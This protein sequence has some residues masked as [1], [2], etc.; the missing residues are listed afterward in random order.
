MLNLYGSDY[1]VH[2]HIAES[3]L[4]AY[5][6][7]ES[8]DIPLAFCYLS[9]FGIPRDVEKAQKILNKTEYSSDDVLIML[10]DLNRRQTELPSVLA[11]VTDDSGHADL[12]R[13]PDIYVEQGRLENAL[14]VLERE[15]KDLKEFSGPDNIPA[16]DIQ[17]RRQLVD[18]YDAQGQYVELQNLLLASLD[19]HSSSRK[20]ETDDTNVQV[21]EVMSL[22]AADYRFLKRWEDAKEVETYL[23]NQAMPSETSQT[24]THDKEEGITTPK[25]CPAT[26]HPV[27][28]FSQLALGALQPGQDRSVP[29]ISTIPDDEPL[30]WLFER[31]A[32]YIRHRK[33]RN[34]NRVLT[35]TRRVCKSLI[36]EHLVVL[37]TMNQLTKVNMT[38]GRYQVAEPWAKDAI[39]MGRQWGENHPSVLV[40]KGNLAMISLIMDK[41]DRAESLAKELI[42]IAQAKW[43]EDHDLTQYGWRILGSTYGQ[44]GKMDE[45]EEVAKK[46]VAQNKKLY[47]DENMSTLDAV[48]NLAVIYHQQGDL[49]AAEEL[50]EEALRTCVKMLGNRHARSLKRMDHLSM[51]LFEQGETTAA[52]ILGESCLQKRRDVLGSQHPDTASSMEAMAKIRSVQE[53]Q[54]EAMLLLEECLLARKSV[55]GEGH[56]H[57]LKVLCEMAKVRVRQCRFD[58]AIS[59]LETCTDSQRRFLGLHHPDLMSSLSLLATIYQREGRHQSAIA[60]TAE[61]IRISQQN[62]GA[63]HPDT[64]RAIEYQKR[65]ERQGQ[66]RIN[67]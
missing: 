8:C 11:R 19:K 65:L 36:S 44:Q 38:L 67:P 45:A 51:I 54:E 56:P 13:V 1:R 46:L 42:H 66:P 21:H 30:L 28:A 6:W 64:R 58:D 37:D 29:G 60:S 41:L 62:Y 35:D 25:T 7:D 16:A 26:G 12:G 9:G 3:L 52:A 40:G 32:S 59:L 4:E 31:C 5:G 34:I 18:I 49:D 47:G 33:W 2:K 24:H 14:K 20:L 50:A 15:L 43:G 63:N 23:K 10:H 55:Y 39:Q 22:L 53:R 27:E 61:V 17:L 48:S 57:T